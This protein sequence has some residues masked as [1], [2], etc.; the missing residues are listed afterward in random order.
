M[1][2]AYAQALCAAILRIAEGYAHT[3]C[4]G[5]RLLRSRAERGQPFPMLGRSRP[6]S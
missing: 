1:D 6:Y 4:P 3:V 5:E 2:T